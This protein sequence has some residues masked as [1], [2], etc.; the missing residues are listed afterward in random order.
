MSGSSQTFYYDQL[1]NRLID[2]SNVS[3][4]IATTA[5]PKIY[6]NNEHFIVRGYVYSDASTSTKANLASLTMS[7]K[8]GTVGSTA[9][10][11][12]NSASCNQT[13]DWPTSVNVSSGQIC[14]WVNT[15]GSAVD[16]ALGSLDSKTYAC[17]INGND[18]DGD[19]RTIAQ[20]NI[21]LQNT[22]D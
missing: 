7:V 4:V 12:A 2:G 8:I 16:T 9:L 5:Y 11:T 15:A 13:A 17:N 6:R 21:V 10:L 20:L 3:A 18:S 22:P 19:D 14:F 1:N